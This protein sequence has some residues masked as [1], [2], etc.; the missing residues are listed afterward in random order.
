MGIQSKPSVDR[1]SAPV[2]LS[3]VI[4]VYNGAKTIVPLVEMLQRELGGKYDLEVVLVNDC[5]ADS[6]ADKCRGL[7][8]RFSWVKFINLSK[9]FG[10]HNAVMAGLSFCTGDC[11]VILDDD[12]QNPPSEVDKLASKLQ[13]GYDVVF[14]YYEKKQHHFL[15]NLGSRFN[16]FIATTLLNKPFDLYLC[17]FKV[18]NRF[19]I[20]EVTKY[21]GPYPYLDGLIL[22]TTRNYG[23]QL[24]EHSKREK[25]ESNYTTVKLIRLWLNM[26]TNFSILPLRVAS[27]VGFLFSLLGFL[28]A[29][30]IVIEKIL[31]PELPLGW[32]SLISTVL[33]VSGV[34][35]FAIGMIGE[36][37]GRLFLKDNGSPQYVAR[38]TVNCEP[39]E[40]QRS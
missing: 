33:I 24:V 12:F 11:A 27:M 34:Q 16:N 17:S 38:E 30:S 10:E 8:E 4:P 15:R 29:I 31:N 3:A 5:S 23:T 13:E 20:D 26:F 1:P 36:Y 35:L 32:T 14:A 37:L 7:A 18:I 39:V 6:S 21:Q 2:R 25:G 40:A 28:Y 9:N 22:R 19:L